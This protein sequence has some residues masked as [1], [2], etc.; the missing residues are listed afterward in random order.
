MKRIITF[1]ILSLLLSGS[2]FGQGEMDAFNLS[3]NDLTGT[4]RSVAMGGAF[5]ALGGDVSGISINPAGIGV[6][7]SSEL[8]T[9]LN[10]T[11]AKTKTDLSGIKSEDSKF[12]FMFDNLAFVGAVPLYSDDV[13]FLNFGF[14]YNKLKSFDRKISARGNGL[15]NSLTNYIAQEANGQKNYAGITSQYPYDNANWLSA[16]GY[17]GTLIEP[18]S[19]GN[20]FVPAYNIKGN[21]KSLNSELYMREN[22]DISS[23][24]FNMGTTIS[25]IISLGL[26]VAVTDIS[27]RLS[28]DYDETFNPSGDNFYL[29]NILKTDGTSWQLKAGLIFKPINELRIGIAYHS[30]TWYDMTDEYDGMTNNSWDTNHGNYYTPDYATTDYKL[31]T[32]DKWVFSLASVIGQSF[33]L[34]ADYELTNY[35]K[36]KLNDPDS[37]DSYYLDNGFIKKH[38]KNASVFRIGAE[39]RVTPQFSLRVGY[40]WQQSPVKDILKDGSMSGRDIAATAGTIPQYSLAGDAN[41]ITYGLGYRFSPHF[42]TDVAFIMKSRT[43]DLYSFGG[44]DRA[45]LKNNTVTGL[46]TLGYRF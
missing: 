21:D 31:R 30:P 7:K 26:T 8:V 27:Y 5:G 16:L 39:A 32:P 3:Y 38:F 22:G 33:I 2:A 20:G 10:F 35:S 37:D 34:S 17:L 42:Y 45:E 14:S 9:T 13:P 24:D 23:Y 15:N 40:M 46:L 28:S 43:D 41:Y 12:K 19:A 29:G 11:N 1:G 36:M 6:Y 18:N 25:D 4:A 44:A